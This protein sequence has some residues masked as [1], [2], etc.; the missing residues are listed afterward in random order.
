MMLSFDLPTVIFSLLSLNQMPCPRHQWLWLSI[1]ILLCDGIQVRIKIIWLLTSV[2]KTKLKNGD[3][4]VLTFLDCGNVPVFV[5]ENPRGTL[6]TLKIS[7]A[8]LMER[9]P[10]E[11]T[12]CEVYLNSSWFLGCNGVRLQQNQYIRKMKELFTFFRA[13]PILPRTFFLQVSVTIL[14]ALMLIFQILFMAIDC[15]PDFFFFQ[16]TEK[17]SKEKWGLSLSA[18]PNPDF[19]SSE[20]YFTKDSGLD[21]VRNWADNQGV[22]PST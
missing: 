16:K 11:F 5:F 20:F 19:W 8:V 1:K 13:P 7:D 3:K 2:L 17:E 9:L 21:R 18:N 14:E 22:Y 4:F 6:Y 15:S 10:Y 12:S